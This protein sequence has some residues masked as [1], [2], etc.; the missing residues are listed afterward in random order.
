M[1][2]KKRKKFSL[3]RQLKSFT[4]AFEGIR[5]L[6][7]EEH[8]IRIHIIAAFLAL[9]AGLFFQIQVYE[10]IAVI[11]VIAFIIVTEI[12]NTSIEHLADVVSPG[13]DNQIKKIK[14]IA[15]AAVLIAAISAVVVGVIIFLPKIIR[16]FL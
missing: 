13:I 6:W 10:W 16:L 3:T 8:N 1:G 11:L 2:S 5:V 14:D 9:I 4:F 15:A 12:I 7:K